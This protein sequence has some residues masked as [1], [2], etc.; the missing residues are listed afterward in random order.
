MEKVFEKFGIYDFM[1]IWGP[2][3]IAI[4]Y[5]IFTSYK[6]FDNLFKSLGISTN[7]I[8]ESCMLIIIYTAISY[9]AGVILHEIGKVIYDLFKW[10]DSEKITYFNINFK[11]KPRLRTFSR[12]KYD[13]NKTI[14]MAK[15]NNISLKSIISQNSI[16]F[17]K[18]RAALKYAS[19]IDTKRM[20][21]YHS[22]YALA[23]SLSV[24]F[25]IHILLILISLLPCFTTINC[26]L[27]IV[28]IMLV[29]VFYLRAYRY[30]ISWIKNT[31]V[32][33]FLC[34]ILKNQE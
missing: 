28:D 21:M 16:S 26:L 6:F 25:A 4:T 17:E 14:D 15:K 18:A 19:N 30:F 3:A 33:Y 24:A 23:R 29:F 13:Y 8:S 1:G 12:I 27:L 5:Y 11:T 34:F 7:D 31:Y 9:T 2:G 10:F 22:I 32:Q 20:D